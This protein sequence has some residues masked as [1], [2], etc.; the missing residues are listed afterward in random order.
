MSRPFELPSR[1]WLLR[2]DSQVTSRYDF[3]K[4]ANS[5]PVW[6]PDSRRIAFA[7][8]DASWK[9]PTDLMVWTVGEP[10]ARKLF[11]DGK[12]NKPDDWSPDGKFVLCRRNDDFAFSLP[13]QEGAVPAE[14]GIYR[15]FLTLQSLTVLAE[16]ILIVK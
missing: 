9:S 1:L 2:I 7:A 13:V 6:S 15:G 14:V 12:M 10:A 4:T 8:F 3:G 16:V 5:D 11:S